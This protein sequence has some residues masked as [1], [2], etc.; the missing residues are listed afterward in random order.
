MLTCLSS[1]TGWKF[2]NLSCRNTLSQCSVANVVPI[3]RLWDLIHECE[4]CVCMM[5]TCTL[6]CGF[7]T[8]ECIW[9]TDQPDSVSPSHHLFLPC[10]PSIRCV[11]VHACVCVCMRVAATSHRCTPHPHPSSWEVTQFPMIQCG[12]FCSVVAVATL[13]GTLILTVTAPWIMNRESD[14]VSDRGG[15]SVRERERDQ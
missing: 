9:I 14:R 2:L 5:K 11:C 12:C 7:C 15:V 13:R 3:Q 10:P 8:S 6:T 4:M 1:V